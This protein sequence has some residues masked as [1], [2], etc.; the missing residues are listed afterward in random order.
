GAGGTRRRGKAGLGSAFFT[1]ALLLVT[2]A[3]SA[4]TEHVARPGSELYA[5]AEPQGHAIAAVP[6]GW[7]AEAFASTAA[8]RPAPAFHGPLWHMADVEGGYAAIR[9]TASPL[10]CGCFSADGG[11]GSMVY[12]LTEFLGVAGDGARMWAPS[13]G[14][15]PGFNLT[16]Y[17]FGP[18]VTVL[19]AGHLLPF[20]HL[21]LGR[22]EAEGSGSGH[23]SGS[24][25][26]F[27][28]A[29][30]GGLDWVLSGDTSVRLA[31]VDEDVTHF[32]DGLTGRQRNLR[33]V[34]GVVF[35][36]KTK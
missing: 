28:D 22:A 16:T 34:F 24:A 19:I 14:N 12:H 26:A 23:G 10:K 32:R 13:T 1:A 4:Q 18:Q 30:G 27:A 2:A 8:N 7:E 21:L 25:A 3:G 20:G 33:L 11:N 29:L 15:G 35:R 31:E 6:G 5:L 9:S 36:F 17:L